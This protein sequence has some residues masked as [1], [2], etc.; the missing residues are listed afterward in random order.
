MY[1]CQMAASL[2]EAVCVPSPTKELH[3][4]AQNSFKDQLLS[5][6]LPPYVPPAAPSHLYSPEQF[7]TCEGCG[8]K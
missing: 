1:V 8:D 2:V 4:D 5:Q 6:A 7:F 3:P